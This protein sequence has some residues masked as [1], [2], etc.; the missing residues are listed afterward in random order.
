MILGIETFYRRLIMQAINVHRLC[1]TVT[2]VKS[3]YRDRNVITPIIVVLYRWQ[4]LGTARHGKIIY[5]PLH[6]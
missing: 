3:T 2:P 4:F 6:K 1:Y 5:E